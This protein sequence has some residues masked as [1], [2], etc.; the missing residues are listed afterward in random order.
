MIRHGLSIFKILSILRP[1]HIQGESW[2][3]DEIIPQLGKQINRKKQGRQMDRYVPFE[4]NLIAQG[5]IR[6]RGAKNLRL[7]P[8]PPYQSRFG[9]PCGIR[10]VSFAKAQDAS[11]T[12]APASNRSELTCCGSCKGS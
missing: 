12:T 4:S 5:R 10:T 1:L 11:E 6:K 8:P 2:F 7:R 9:A 3:G